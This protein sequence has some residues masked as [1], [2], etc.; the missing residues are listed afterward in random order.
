MKDIN[1]GKELISKVKS[2]LKNYDFEIIA[3]EVKSELT[4]FAESY[5]HQNVAETNLNLTVKIINEN[6]IGAVQMN[7]IDEPTISKNIEKAIE[8]TK[9]TPKLD[10]HYRLLTPQSYKIKSKHSK[11][12]ANFTPLNRAQLVSQLIKEVNKRGYEAAGAFKTEE[13]TLLVANSEGVFAFDR[14][15]KVDFNCVITRD[16]ILI[17][18]SPEIILLPILHL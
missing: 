2:F 11:D 7:S 16:N 1:S 18:L 12:T 13:S 8:V 17:V 5:I 4:R 15:T 6:K 10:Y 3:T 14:G 9:I